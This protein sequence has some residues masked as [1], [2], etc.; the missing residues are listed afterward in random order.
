M[1]D[2]SIIIVNWNTR[3][4]TADCLRS[5]QETAGDLHYE[6]ILVDNASSDGSPAMIREQFGWVKLIENQ[7]N[8]GFAGAN[9]QGMAVA[10]GRYLLLLNSDTV[11]K[12]GAFQSAMQFMDAHP[13]AGLCG[14]RLL[15][16]DGGFQASYADF[17]SL[18]AEFL[19]ATGLGK[20]FFSPYYPS[21][22]PQSN[23]QAHEIDWVAGAF[24]LLRREVYAR[25]GGMDTSYWMYSEETDWCYRIQQSGYKLFYLP[26]VAIIHIG[27]ASTRQRK[28]EMMAQL[29]KSKVHFFA[30]NYGAARARQ[31]QVLLWIVYVARELAGRVLMLLPSFRDRGQREVHVARLI[32]AAC[33][34]AVRG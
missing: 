29:T 10:E 11:V 8:P 15:N 4:I 9:N 18:A 5:I 26:D 16:P 7:D 6:V 23:E 24:M 13:E 20:R 27:G 32:R 25:V 34:Q 30:K 1:L 28:P 33:A 2:L 31:L 17:P 3:Q 22:R 14:I 12:P 21:P 19:T